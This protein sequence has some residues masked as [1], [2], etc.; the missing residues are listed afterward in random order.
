MIIGY[1]R[2]STVEQ[3]AG[4][5]SQIKAL[6]LAG[7]D[8]IFQEQ[9]SSVAE[10]VQLGQ[11]MDFAREGDQFVVTKLDRLARSV[12][13]LTEIVDTLESKNVSLRILDIGLDTKTPT[14]KLMLNMLGSVAQ[15]E[16]EIMLERQREGIMKAKRE[17]KY[18]GRPST[19]D[20]DRVHELRAA[21]VSIKG[22]QEE[23][24]ISRATI[25]RYLKTK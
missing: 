20:G 16:R 4:F 25:Y 17:G 12:K 5:E 7:A 11:A 8:K 22:I 6:E 18:K 3:K 14:G 1:A 24:L 19:T 23:L 9:V 21:G 2:T 15:F 10:R 13:H